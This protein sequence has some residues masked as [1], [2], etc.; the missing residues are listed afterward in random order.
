[1]E[2]GFSAAPARGGKIADQ[3]DSAPRRRRRAPRGRLRQAAVA[4]N[5]ARVRVRRGIVRAG[6]RARRGAAGANQVRARSRPGQT[7]TLAAGG[8]PRPA[9]V[10]CVYGQPI[11][12]GRDS[13]QVRLRRLV[14]VKCERPGARAPLYKG[15][16]V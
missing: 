11:V 14:F 3:P 10:S 4:D 6:V 13:V 2:A 12:G 16:G 15:N 7:Q 8:C 1:M 9:G 5:C